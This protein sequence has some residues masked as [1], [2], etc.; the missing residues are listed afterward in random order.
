[1]KLTIALIGIT[2]LVISLNNITF[3]QVEFQPSSIAP[4][5]P[6]A[7]AAAFYYIA[8]PGEVT[9]QVNIWG[10]VQKPGR[11]EIPNGT[12]LIRLL[13]YAGGPL[14]YANLSKIKIMRF[15][16]SDNKILKED[17]I[18]NLEDM[19]KINEANI[20]LQPGDT[21]FIENTTW[22]YIKEAFSVIT[23]AAVITSAIANIVWATRR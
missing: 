18:V 21:I 8:K 5:Y 19:D 16:K 4:T 13:S 9:I 17:F 20:I 11:F 23:T 1:M 14:Q 2:F 15:T 22:F 3:S 7:Q 12:D 10:Q 6:S